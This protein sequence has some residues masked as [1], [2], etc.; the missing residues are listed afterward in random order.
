ML[1]LD[2]KKIYILLIIVALLNYLLS[3]FTGQEFYFCIKPF[4]Y[5]GLTIIIYSFS[6]SKYQVK[7]YKNFVNLITIL[8]II[9]YVLLY[10]LSGIIFEFANNPLK[11]EGINI[12]YNILYYIPSAICIELIRYRTTNNLKNTN[13]LKNIIILNIIL[14]ILMSN[15]TINN[16][17]TLKGSIEAFYQILIPNFVIGCYLSYVSLYGSLYAC[18]IYSLTPIIYTLLSPIIPNPEWIIIVILE[19]IIPIICYNFIDK[20]LPKENQLTKKRSTIP[21]YVTIVL[22]IGIVLFST[23]IFN[24][25]PVAIAS[26]SMS[27]TFKR[28]DIQIIDKRKKEYQK[29]DIIQ[30]Y[31]LNNTIF[32]H[33]IVS[34][35]SEDGKTYYITKGDNN[36]NVDLMEISEDKIIGKSILTVKYLGY[37]TILISEIF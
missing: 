22:L 32:V 15:I 25:Y 5:I 3:A 11:M 26:N 24:V 9:A 1:Q 31:G 33:R 21:Y 10:T 14:A 2:T 16:F 18:I 23:G 20:T 36:N 28:G 37:P 8:S 7:K 6:Y 35:R 29:G 30:F 13:K 4:I 17:T 19:T 12:L 34:K 27:P